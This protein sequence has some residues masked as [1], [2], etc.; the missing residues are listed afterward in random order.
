MDQI[1]LQKGCTNP[2]GLPISSNYCSLATSSSP[3]PYSLQIFSQ[4]RGLEQG[5]I[6][7][8]GHRHPRNLTSTNHPVVDLKD[9]AIRNVMYYYDVRSLHR[10]VSLT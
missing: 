9:V 1:L 5:R 7:K 6:T 4:H 8:W 3:Y 2:V 10:Q